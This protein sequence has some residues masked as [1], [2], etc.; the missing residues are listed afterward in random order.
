MARST[1][2]FRMNA[3]VMKRMKRAARESGMPAEQ[4]AVRAVEWYLSQ[5]A[6]EAQ[7]LPHA[8]TTPVPTGINIGITL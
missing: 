6:I 5:T 4:L 7:V 8:E 2:K 3:N 1:L